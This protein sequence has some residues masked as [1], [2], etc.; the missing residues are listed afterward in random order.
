LLG[1]SPAGRRVPGR[2]EPAVQRWRAAG[3]GSGAAGEGDVNADADSRR[4]GE[5]GGCV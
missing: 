4:A 2:A 5:G 1:S 3:P